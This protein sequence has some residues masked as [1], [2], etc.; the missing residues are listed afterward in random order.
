M[1]VKRRDFLKTSMYCPLVTMAP[2]IALSEPNDPISVV[3]SHFFP[4]VQ[5]SQQFL[6]EFKNFLA[7]DRANGFDVEVKPK[8]FERYIVEEF[9]LFSNHLQ[10]VRGLEVSYRA[11]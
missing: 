2:N 7:E 3:I 11:I 5:L 9:I 10:I 4:S 6:T 1:N 8:D